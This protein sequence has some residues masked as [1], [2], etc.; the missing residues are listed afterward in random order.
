[1]NKSKS[2]DIFYKESSNDIPI[3]VCTIKHPTFK[4]IM[5]KVREHSGH[6]NANARNI[7]IKFLDRENEVLVIKKFTN[8]IKFT[9]A[10]PISLNHLIK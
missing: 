5:Q 3:M 7:D 6:V 8:H 2:Y 4:S 9:V 10:L 1:M